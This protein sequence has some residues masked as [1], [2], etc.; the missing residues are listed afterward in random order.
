MDVAIDQP[1]LF[2][3]AERQ[4]KKPGPFRQ[5]MAAIREHGTLVPQ[6]MIAGTLK[7]SKQRVSQLIQAGR[8]ASL[9][10]GGRHWIPLAA[11]ELYLSEEKKAGRPVMVPDTYREFRAQLKKEY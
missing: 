8:L 10:I 11:L 2:P 1:E 5:L 4:A 3:F 9:E 7:L 6:Q